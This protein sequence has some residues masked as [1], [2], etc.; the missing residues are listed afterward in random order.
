MTKWSVFILEL[1]VLNFNNTVTSKSFCSGCG[2]QVRNSVLLFVN[3]QRNFDIWISFASLSI[4]WI[5]GWAMNCFQIKGQT[6]RREQLPCDSRLTL[7]LHCLW[8]DILSSS[9]FFPCPSVCGLTSMLMWFNL[10]SKL[11]LNRQKL[12][13]Q[14]SNLFRSNPDTKSSYS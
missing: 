4:A 13:M 1:H 14:Q 6:W 8:L 10:A 5:V 11:V 7:T 2:A 9:W 12:W 3:N